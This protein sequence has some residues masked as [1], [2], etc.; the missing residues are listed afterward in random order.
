M[1]LVFFSSAV[2]DDDVMMLVLE[3]KADALLAAVC[4]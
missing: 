4:A 3:A 1:V 2:A